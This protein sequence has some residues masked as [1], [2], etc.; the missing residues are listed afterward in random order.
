MSQTATKVAG[1]L[2]AIKV[3]GGQEKNVAKLM[4]NRVEVNPKEREAIYAIL[5]LEDLKG[6]VFVEASNVQAI[7][8]SSSGLKH[9]RSQMP[10]SI[11]IQDLEHLLISKPIITEIKPGDIVEIVGGPLKG[12]KA[13]VERIEPA[14]SEVTVVLLEAAREI[15]VTVDTSYLKIV[16]KT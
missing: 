16:Q 14:R 15:P 1:K 7:S 9:V 3:T 8:L 11:Q 2:F 6:Y 10:G 12:M 5:A 13:K 4:A